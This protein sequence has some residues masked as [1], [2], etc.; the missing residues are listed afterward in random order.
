MQQAKHNKGWLML[1]ALTL[2]VLL[3]P[4]RSTVQAAPTAPQSYPQDPNTNMADWWPGSSA[5]VADIESVF[6]SARAAE[7]AQ[8]GKS[9]PMLTLPPQAAWN[10][11]D[12]NAR[13]LWLANRERI[14]R[15]VLPLQGT[16]ANVTSVAQYYAQ[17]LLSHNTFS[18]NA[19]GKDPWQRLN[20]NPAINA[21]HDFVSIAENLY[22][23]VTSG[24]SIALPVEQAIYSWMYTDSGNSWGHRHTLLWYPYNDNSGPAGREGFLG[25]GQA[26]GGPYQGPFS[27]PWNHAEIIVM[28]VFDPCQTWQYV[29][30]SPR[31]YLPWS[32]RG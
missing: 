24:N 18:H 16:E 28:N 7:N 6:N 30:T 11:M 23:S 20:T 32:R 17:Y 27:Q 29:T 12:A 14:D 21:C 5:G 26:G 8:L 13:A 31:T 25:I 15:G 22:V 1:V 4:V 2:A 19:D 9:I 10:G 3:L